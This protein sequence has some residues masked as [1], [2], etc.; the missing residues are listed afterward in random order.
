MGRWLASL[1]ADYRSVENGVV[2]APSR[3]PG[4]GGG[5]PT[6]ALAR[7]DTRVISKME[8]TLVLLT[9]RAAVYL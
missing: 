2:S 1:V 8:R 9:R 7:V 4:R 6:R 3:T 5:A